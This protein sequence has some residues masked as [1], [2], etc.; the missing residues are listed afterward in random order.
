MEFRSVQPTTPLSIKTRRVLS[1]SRTEYTVVQATKLIFRFGDTRPK[2][3]VEVLLAREIIVVN[4]KLGSKPLYSWKQK[5]SPR[6][7][8]PIV[9]DKKQ[10]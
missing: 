9:K 4:S 7:E 8:M 6:S 5:S 10:P 3:G 2:G 1:N